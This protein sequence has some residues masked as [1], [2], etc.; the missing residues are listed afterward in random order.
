M[1][2]INLTISLLCGSIKGFCG[3]KTS[4]YLNGI[5][6][7][8]LANLIRMSFCIIIGFCI[9]MASGNFAQLKPTSELLVISLI[10]GLTTTVFVVSWLLCVKQ[11]A[12]MLLDIFLMSGILIPILYGRIFLNENIRISQWIGIAILL[13]AVIVMCSYNNS[14]KQNLSF[15]SVALLVCCGAANGI[16]D[17]S[18]KIFVS[19]M[20]DISA[21]VFSFYTYIFAALF[22]ALI[23]FVLK[24][25]PSE[26]QKS[27]YLKIMGYIAVM[28]ICLFGNTYF[29]TIAAKSLDSVI[30]YPLNQ[31][32]SL[33]LST[34][35]AA[36]FFK[37]KLTL[38]CIIGIILAF[39]GV[40][41]INML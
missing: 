1:G 17:L 15:S 2:Y 29:K 19:H 18:Q 25:E 35:M 30:L 41:T 36:F 40:F 14:I 16:T 26:A 3:K 12:Y 7:S 13:I 27:D 23:I 22:L 4:G 6:A 33:T 24:K 34:F 10:S 39:I 31:A 37:E 11:N 5:K 32:G 28:S 21:T 8:S 20:P 38:K 9:I